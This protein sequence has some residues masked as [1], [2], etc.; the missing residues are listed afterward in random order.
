MKYKLFTCLLL[1]F[2]VNVN[3]NELMLTFAKK[4]P[5]MP[6]IS[7]PDYVLSRKIDIA[8][9]ASATQDPNKKSRMIGFTNLGSGD[10]YFAVSRTPFIH[11]TKPSEGA[12]LGG[13]GISKNIILESELTNIGVQAS[14]IIESGDTDVACFLKNPVRYGDIDKNGQTDLIIFMGRGWQTDMHLFSSNSKKTIFSANLSINHAFIPSAED[15]ENIYPS[16]GKPQNPQYLSDWVN[17]SPP[18]LEEGFRSFGKIFLEDFDDD[19]IKE[20]LLWRKYFVSKKLED[21][22]KGFEKIR[23]TFIHYKLIDG[24][25]KKQPTEQD[26]IKSWLAAKNLTWQK[27][28]PSKSECPGQE[29]QLI[30][31]MHDPLL[32][33]P[34]VL[35]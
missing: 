5:E 22:I 1:I 6:T 24:E 18:P 26:E 35:K 30:P 31:E 3:S 25:Y 23:D 9:A 17:G 20:I 16:Y 33:D 34:D 11:L 13:W 4:R 32:N 15:I 14:D 12:Y 10:E 28:Y 2:C 7:N 27:G 8:I 21:P 19:E 29:G